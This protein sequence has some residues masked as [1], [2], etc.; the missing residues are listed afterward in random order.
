MK[1]FD[2]M[3]STYAR[4]SIANQIQYDAW[5]NAEAKAAHALIGL[6]RVTYTYIHYALLVTGFIFMALRLTKPPQKADDFI[7]EYQAKEK[8]KKAKALSVV[9]TSEGSVTSIKPVS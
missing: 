6:Q 1:Y 2:Y 3:E 7:K 9:P 8:D 5:T 4:K